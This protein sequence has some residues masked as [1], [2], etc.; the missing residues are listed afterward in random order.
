MSGLALPIGPVVKK[1][2]RI[3]ALADL[4]GAT[5]L[6]R[7]SSSILAA[8]SLRRLRADYSGNAV[9]V[10]RSSDNAEQDIGFVGNS[11]DTQALTT[12]C[13]AASG[14]VTTWYDQIGNT[15]NAI[16]ATAANQPTIV[17]AGVLQTMNARPAIMWADT[18]NTQNLAF[19]NFSNPTSPQNH[20][21][22]GQFSGP[23]P[24]T[25]ARAAFTFD[26]DDGSNRGLSFLTNAAGSTTFFRAVH[27]NGAAASITALPTIQSP[28]V[29]RNSDPAPTANRDGWWIGN[30]RGIANRGWRGP[31]TEVVIAGTA[32]TAG[33]INALQANMGGYYGITIA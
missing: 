33:E 7:L 22:V 24:F 13:G 16:Q 28:F 14:L 19:I 2:G 8:Y 18:L 1:G 31:I 25:E 11:L 20:F 17:S 3:F 26:D 32:L 21:V 23:N 6:D 15:R 29:G 4:L 10:R 27:L 9:R 30:D 12:F 5:P